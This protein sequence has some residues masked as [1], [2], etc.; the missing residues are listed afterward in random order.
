MDTDSRA[1]LW[2]AAFIYCM[3]NAVIFDRRNF[4]FEHT[5]DGPVRRLLDTRSRNSQLRHI[6][7]SGM[8]YR[9]LDDDALP[10]G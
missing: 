4:G 3:V 8:V 9:A 2:V 1:R 10:E 6:G 5:G 7:A